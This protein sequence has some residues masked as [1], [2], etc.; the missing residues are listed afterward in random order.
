M[1]AVGAERAD[2]AHF[3]HRWII[4]AAL[5]ADE[6]GFSQCRTAPRVPFVRRTAMAAA[7][8]GASV[9]AGDRF[10]DLL[11]QTCNI[12]EADPDGAVR[13]QRAVP[14]GYLHVDRTEAN[15]ATLRILHERRRVIE[16]HRLVVE[17]RPVERRRDMRVAGGA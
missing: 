13:F 14:V 2:L 4:A 1:R 6:R 9:G 8:F 7:G 3:E 12:S 15:A 16:P 17:R 10:S 5:R 11:P